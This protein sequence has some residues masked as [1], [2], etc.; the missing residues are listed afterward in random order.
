VVRLVEHQPPINELRTAYLAEANNW[1][2]LMVMVQDH[3]REVA[4]NL[5][6]DI[7]KTTNVKWERKKDLEYEQE[8]AAKR[9]K[10]ETTS[11]G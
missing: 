9:E 8:E 10:E 3:A 2:G 7:T 4:S 1:P 11:G 6:S 5:S